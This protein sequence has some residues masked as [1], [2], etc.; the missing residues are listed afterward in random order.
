MPR[1]FNM[2][3]FVANQASFV[4]SLP[5][6]LK[7]A[8]SQ[9]K[10][11]RLFPQDLLTA[12]FNYKKSAFSLAVLI[13]VFILLLSRFS[14]ADELIVDF[15]DKSIPVL[16]DELRKLR[17]AIELLTVNINDPQAPE[18]DSYWIHDEDEDTYVT[19]EGTAGTGDTDLIEGQTGGTSVFAGDSDQ[20]AVESGIKLGIE[21]DDG[22]SYLEYNSATNYFEL[23]VDGSL[24]VE[25]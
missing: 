4:H 9:L 3:F 17:R 7:A 16:N 13:I 5:P 11:K 23:Y 22:D 14:Y 2:K 15:T 1:W 18:L 25:F 21:G 8:F 20:F 19:T 10:R 12:N 6:K 24:R